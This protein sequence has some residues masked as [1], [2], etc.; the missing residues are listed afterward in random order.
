M[1]ARKE[2]LI[3]AGLSASITFAVFYPFAALGLD[4][5]HDGI[6]LKP[7]IDVYSG[8][9]LFRDTFT[10]YGALTIWMHAVCLSIDPRLLSM[11]MFTVAVYACSVFLLV[12]SWLRFSPWP[13]AAIGVVLFLVS[14]PFYDERWLLLPWSSAIALLFQSA[15]AYS[16]CRMIAN[17]ASDLWPAL[18]GLSTALAFWARPLMVGLSLTLAIIVIWLLWSRSRSDTCGPSSRQWGV[19]FGMFSA[20]NAAFLAVLGLQGALPA[21]F[22]QNV[23]WAFRGYASGRMRGTTAVERFFFELQ[24]LKGLKV[25]ALVLGLCFAFWIA[26]LAAR[27]SKRTRFVLLLPLMAVLAAFGYA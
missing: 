5:H 3:L 16:L 12:L 7:A 18:V 8:Q 10:Q 27:C 26:K 19:V 11:R 4:F 17:N 23:L 6:M 2:R 13:V 1:S 25:L 22:E 9:V 21:F 20:V 14:A 24:P 15:A